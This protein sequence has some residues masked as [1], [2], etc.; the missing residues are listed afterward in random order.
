M[1]CANAVTPESGGTVAGYLYGMDP[2]NATWRQLFCTGE[3]SAS[4]GPDPARFRHA[5]IWTK[6]VHVQKMTCGWDAPFF[7]TIIWSREL[8]TY[9]GFR[10][11]AKKPDWQAFPQLTGRPPKRGRTA[12][13]SLN[14]CD[15]WVTKLI[16]EAPARDIELAG[17]LL[18][19]RYAGPDDLNPNSKI[20]FMGQ[21]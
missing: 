7:K 5:F 14:I 16:R 8:R 19:T 15:A 11:T 10:T 9:T 4:V 20:D 1:K 3:C 2:D 6:D 18:A 17:V 21:R 13:E 12:P